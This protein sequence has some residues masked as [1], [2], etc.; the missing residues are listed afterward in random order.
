MNEADVRRRNHWV[1]HIARHAHAKPD[2]VYL[3]FEGRSVT[4]SQLHQ[5]VSA[6]AAAMSQRGVGA[7]DRVAIMMTNRPEFLETM[8]AVNALGAIA[9]P[10][11]FRLAPDEIAF[12]LTDSGACL[13][14]VD[15]TTG[16][17]AAHARAAGRPGIGFVSAGATDG[18][19]P[20][21]PEPDGTAEPP[22]VDVPEDSPAL[23]MYTSGTTGQPKGAVLSHQNLQCQALTVI[24]AW[25]L[26]DDHEVNLCAAPMFHIASIGTV[27][28][29]ALIG[30][31]MVL[32]PSGGFNAATTLETMEAERTTCMFLVPS[33]WQ[34]VCADP[35][36]A[37]HDLS[38]LKVV[39]WGAAPA[40]TT[41]LIQM[42]EAFPRAANVAVFG[43]TEMSPVTCA[44]DG[45]DALRKIGSVGRPVTTVSARIVDG[46]MKDVPPGE[47]GE[48]VYRG[49]QVMSGYWQNPEATA[50]ALR[51]GWF[52]SGDLVRADEDG[53]LYVVDRKKDMII[54][55]G[56]NVYCAEVENALASHPAVAELAV[57]GAPHEQ[58]GETPAAV[59]AL[60]PGALLT[61]DELREWG[62]GRLARYKLPTILHLVPALPRNASGKVMKTVLRRQFG[63]PR[64]QSR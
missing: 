14:V 61:I 10:I 3:R 26:F 38:A 35:T 50:E 23:I 1:N 33:Q 24:R 25:R 31:T 53:F 12:I 48:I 42:A 60:H 2:A 8:F 52:H 57:I 44:L 19:D 16:P 20:Y 37:G 39:S 15:E 18:A 34:L 40:T 58:W 59:A 64:G 45:A 63:D 47:V 9:V 27:A 13:L 51:G 41:L 21:F 55:G 30:A 5:R 28:P 56:E 49:P 4:W 46:D 11:N 7:G 32:L 36:L 54:T 22:A 17:A 62:T 29:I 43:Q 6:I